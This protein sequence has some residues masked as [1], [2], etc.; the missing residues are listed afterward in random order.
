MTSIT[1]PLLNEILRVW[2]EN[3]RYWQVVTLFGNPLL[4]LLMD[5]EKYDQSLVKDWSK[6]VL[7]YMYMIICSSRIFVIELH[8]N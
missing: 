7:P 2:S 1:M 8:A 4:F 3:A 5:L 6:E